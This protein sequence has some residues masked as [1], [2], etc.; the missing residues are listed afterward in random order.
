MRDKKLN[1][2][3]ISFVVDPVTLSKIDYLY[4]IWLSENPGGSKGQFMRALFNLGCGYFAKRYNV[5]FPGL[6]LHSLTNVDFTKSVL[7]SL[8]EKLTTNINQQ[9]DSLNSQKVLSINWVDSCYDRSSI[10]KCC[11]VNA[12]H[13]LDL[14][15]R[16]YALMSELSSFKLS[17]EAPSSTKKLEVK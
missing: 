10:A 5:N 16:V 3:M 6:D 11:D 9:L 14:I 7:M 17:L 1:K 8:L 12:R 15:G 2:K 4:D 13:Y